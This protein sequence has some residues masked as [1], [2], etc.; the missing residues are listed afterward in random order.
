MYGP[1]G[2]AVC[3][4]NGNVVVA[5]SNNNRILIYSPAGKLLRSGSTEERLYMNNPFGIAVDDN[6]TIVVSDG[7]TTKLRV[8]NVHGKQITKFPEPKRGRC[9]MKAVVIGKNG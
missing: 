4:S 8:F 7:T 5:D 2:I 9:D 1:T 6:E 3:G